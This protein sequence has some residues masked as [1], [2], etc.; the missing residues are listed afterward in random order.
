MIILNVDVKPYQDWSLNA[1]YQIR[2]SNCPIG[3]FYTIAVKYTHYRNDNLFRRHLYL[4][5]LAVSCPTPLVY[6]E[7][8]NKVCEPSCDSL[9]QSDP[10]PK[11]PG[12]CFPGCYC[13]DGYIK[14]SGSCVKPSK[15]RNCNN[16]TRFSTLYIV[17]E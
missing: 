9:L 12:L 4:F 10:C 1:T 8:F 3:E 13:P 2:P 7:C 5:F 16:R 15:C 14:E 6:K 11:L 17:V